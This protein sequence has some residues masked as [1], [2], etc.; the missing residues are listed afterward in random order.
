MLC[1][2]HCLL[3][4]VAL[5]IVP[6]LAV[7]TFGDERFHQW[8]LLAV[9]PTSLIALTLGCRRHRHFSVMA[10]GLIGLSI[11]TLAAFQGH[12]LFGETGEKIASLLGASLIALAHLRNHSLCKSLQCDCE[13]T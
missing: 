8:I 5:V 6:A 11:L 4:P 13:H 3:L 2:A 12:T 10:A 9:L 1:A 7:N